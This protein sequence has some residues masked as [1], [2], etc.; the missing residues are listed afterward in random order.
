MYGLSF[1]ADGREF[2][3]VM[4]ECDNGGCWLL[5]LA[6]SH[7]AFVEYAVS[8]NAAACVFMTRKPGDDIRMVVDELE[9]LFVIPGDSV[10]AGGFREN[11]YVR[12]DDCTL[13]MGRGICQEAM[14]PF[15]AFRRELAVE[16]PFPWVGLK[17]FFR[18]LKS[19]GARRRKDGFIHGIQGD[20]TEIADGEIIE[21]TVDAT[22]SSGLR[23]R[24][25]D[26]VVVSNGVPNCVSAT[27]EDIKHQRKFAV[28]IAVDEV[29]EVEDE[30]NVWNI[31]EDVD[32]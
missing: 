21:K 16:V 10:R 3:A 6:V 29:A 28:R 30:I 2:H 20:E 8:D 11:R 23:S 1:H 9:H 12:K 32:Q 31:V 13:S 27:A 26:Q 18:P 14:Q 5:S 4:V 17:Q 15:N 7:D 19:I 22:E 24:Q 25:L